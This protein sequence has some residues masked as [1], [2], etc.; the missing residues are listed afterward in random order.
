MQTRSTLSK[1]YLM[2]T[3]KHPRNTLL[4]VGSRIGQIIQARLR[5]ECSSL[6]AHLYSKNIVPTPSYECGAFENS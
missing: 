2:E 6:N 1:T 4:K 5:M 3:D